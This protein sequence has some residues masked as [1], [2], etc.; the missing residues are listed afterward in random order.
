MGL[1][2]EELLA[3]FKSTGALLEG[4]FLLSSGLHSPHYFQCAKVLQYPR[5]LMMLCEP[6]A[7]HFAHSNID[8]VISPALGGIVVGTEVGRQLNVRTIFAE[9]EN[10]VM[11]LR[12]GFEIQPGERCLVVEDVVTT[13]GSVREVIRIIQD[14]GGV[15]AG[16]GFIVDRSNGKVQLADDQFSLL[17]LDVVA[18]PPDQVPPELAKI[19]LTKPGSR[20]QPSSAA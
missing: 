15:V 7:A 6:I 12:R 8:V 16:V 2:Q 19:P 17:K 1:S 14:R 18:Y 4:H 11:T 5:Y 20:P 3:L 13:G 9:R 10:G